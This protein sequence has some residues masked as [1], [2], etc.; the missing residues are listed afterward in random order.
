[1]N[2]ELRSIKAQEQ[3]SARELQEQ[4]L[5][6]IEGKPLENLAAIA[7]LQATFANAALQGLIEIVRH[8]NILTEREVSIALR[9][10]YDRA[11]AQLRDRDHG[12]IIMPPA[13][14]VATPQ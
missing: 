11:L 14:V 9:R 1:M 12:Q 8:K 13:P 4:L 6:T 3:L 5:R 7:T 2:N 10:G